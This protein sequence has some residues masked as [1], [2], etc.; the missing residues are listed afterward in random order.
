MTTKRQHLVWRKYLSSW[1][2][3]PETTD[4]KIFVYDIKTGEIRR[5]NINK[6]AVETYTYDISGRSEA[7]EL[8]CKSFLNYWFRKNNLPI[9]A[10]QF[11]FA[12]GD[13]EKDFIENQYISK[14][15][16]E[17][18]GYLNK[19][20]NGDFPYSGESKLR[21]NIKLFEQNL[22]TTLLTGK[23]TLSEQ[24]NDCIVS[25][26]QEL[27]KTKDERLSFF[28]FFANQ[29]LRTIRGR[30]AVLDA[31]ESTK[32]RFPE[33]ELY[34]RTTKCLFPL[35]MC[36]NT[37]I[38]AYSLWKGDFYLEILLNETEENLIT[39]DEPIINLRVDYLNLP[40]EEISVM[41]LYYPVTPKIGLLCKH[42]G[43]KNMKRAIK[44]AE[45]IRM[46]NS[47]MF[48]GA[49]RQVFSWREDDF[50]KIPK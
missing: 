36:A 5:S 9:D 6:V 24:E 26:S 10:N 39:S 18:L 37:L 19:L 4:G 40:A 43:S 12:D 16:C 48:Q 7:D 17:G 2:D 11:V 38:M 31:I 30:K 23:S 21:Q 44:E 46:L 1:T 41:D 3:M 49:S 32:K 25:Q 45:E 29:F 42:G 34:Q 33:K 13:A 14:V 22:I 50:K 20:R 35:I 47:K 8:L 28:E 27:S 15:E